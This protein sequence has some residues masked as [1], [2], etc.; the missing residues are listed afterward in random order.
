MEPEGSLAWSK[1]PSSG[2]YPEPDESSPRHPVPFLYLLS[3]FI[4]DIIT[5]N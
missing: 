5:T 4:I 2:T 1:E 3:T